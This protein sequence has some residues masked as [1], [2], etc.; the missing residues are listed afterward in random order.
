MQLYT[1]TG[2]ISLISE[3]GF[4]FSKQYGQNFLINEAVVDRIAKSCRD[5]QE[6]GK[7][8]CLEIGPGIGSLTEKLCD[9]FDRVLSLE[10]DKR[11]MP[12]LDKTVGRRENLKIVNCDAMK[13]DL[14]TMIAEELSGDPVSVCANLPYYI[15]SQII[16]RL[17][18]CPVRFTSLVL[19]IQK[20][21]ASRLAALPGSPEYGAITAAVN[22]RA[23]VKK[24]FDVQPG[25]FMPRPKVTSTVIMI[26]P[27]ENKPFVPKNE[28]LLS[29]LIRASFA[30]RRKT[31][32]NTVCSAM[33]AYT[34]E[35]IEKAFDCAGVDPS[36]RGE[37]LTIA[38]LCRISD[39]L[40]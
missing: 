31:A 25:S 19:M 38:E 40:E 4:T 35:Q 34:R 17:L 8:A 2:I 39:A 20:E 11:L 7:A 26:S 28:K 29:E 12:I 9:R 37:T 14:E 22:Y 23:S 24:L 32:V 21:V 1:P 13:A 15:T 6:G 18:E 30:Q 27:Y 16:M 3:A 36:R 10:I 33:G 5:A